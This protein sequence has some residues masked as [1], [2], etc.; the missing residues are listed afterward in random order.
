MS[1]NQLVAVG[2]TQGAWV[3]WAERQ[4]PENRAVQQVMPALVDLA[5][6]LGAVTSEDIATLARSAAAANVDTTSPGSDAQALLR[7]L[8][9]AGWEPP[10]LRKSPYVLKE[11]ERILAQGECDALV[12]QAVPRKKGHSWVGGASPI[13]LALLAVSAAANAAQTAKAAHDAAATWRPMGQGHSL[14][15]VSNLRVA[16]RVVGP[17]GTPKWNTYQL[18]DIYSL[19]L[20]AKPTALVVR[21]AG[22]EY[23]P[24]RYQMP[25]AP[26]WFALLAH[27]APPSA[28]PH[29]DA[30]SAPPVAAISGPD[31]NPPSAG[32]SIDALRP[33]DRATEPKPW[34]PLTVQSP[35]APPLRGADCFASP[36]A[37]QASS[38]PPPA[39]PEAPPMPPPLTLVCWQCRSVVSSTNQFCPR[40][41]NPLHKATTMDREVLTPPSAAPNPPSSSNTPRQW[42]NAPSIRGLAPASYPKKTET[43]PPP[44]P[45]T[46]VP[47]IPTPSIVCSQC[48]SLIS[49][50]SR[51]CPKCST[52]LRP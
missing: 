28:L 42:A 43:P 5:Q 47:T 51:F 52:G 22:K 2:N 23:T 27:L 39:P 4:Y 40:C 13:G 33:A 11:G 48:H 41:G 35:T 29:V 31:L 1:T 10:G 24:F 8:L 37:A 6:Q 15:C 49:V 3:A 32:S 25:T 36:P 34:T 9:A 19:S 45:S 16:R 18:S 46:A 17:D 20:E 44:P 38:A 21:I 12:W 26:V 30:P 7:A 14:L 50:P